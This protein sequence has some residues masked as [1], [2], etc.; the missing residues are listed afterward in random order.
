MHL[1][2]GAGCHHVQARKKLSGPRVFISHSF[3]RPDPLL[4][5][6]GVSTISFLHLRVAVDKI[7]RKISALDKRKAIQSSCTATASSPSS[8]PT[9]RERMLPQEWR[10]CSRPDVVP[11]F[12]GTVGGPNVCTT[13]QVVLATLCHPRAYHTITLNT[14]WHTKISREEPVKRRVRFYQ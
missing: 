2:Y 1:H 9:S 7:T 14:K 6:G 3:L 8:L 10:G 11:F 5:R 4:L 13:S 12:F